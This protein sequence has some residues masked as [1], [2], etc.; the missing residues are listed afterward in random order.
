MLDGVVSHLLGQPIFVDLQEVP[1][2]LQ[3]LLFEVEL[4][5]NV[6]SLREFIC[7][8]IIHLRDLLLG[9]LHLLVDSELKALHLLE[10]LV[11]VLLLNLELGGSG[12]RVVKLALL[13]LK[14]LLHVIDLN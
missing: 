5:L 13:E 2:V 8:V 6:I 12:R 9:L 14:I 3:S 7:D 1:D 11:D 4:P 10:V